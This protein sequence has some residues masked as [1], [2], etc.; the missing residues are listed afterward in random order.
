M[1]GTRRQIG[2][3]LLLVSLAL[4]S[5]QA[6]SPRSASPRSASPGPAPEIPRTWQLDEIAGAVPAPSRSASEGWTP[7]ATHVLAWKTIDAGPD[8]EGDGRSSIDQCLLLQQ[9]TGSGTQ[10]AWQ[11]AL[12][13][14]NSWHNKWKISEIQMLMPGNGGEGPVCVWQRG[15]QTYGSIPTSDQ[16]YAFM[17]RWEWKLEAGEGRRLLEGRVCENTWRWLL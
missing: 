3:T 17:D 15:V 8:P 16:V 1:G 7:V 14:R 12:V 11:L 4:P 5:C 13:F 2:L 6:P 9:W 10:P